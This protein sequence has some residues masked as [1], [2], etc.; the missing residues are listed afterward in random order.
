MEF[1]S[2]LGGPE[3]YECAD[4]SKFECKAGTQGCFA[5][6]PTYCNEPVE[7]RPILGGP[8][9]YECED[10]SKFECNAGT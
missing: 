3:T 10:G 6:S 2:I 1:V 5:N 9:T 8:V 4:G 7:L